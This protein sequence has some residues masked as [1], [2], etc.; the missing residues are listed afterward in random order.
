MALSPITVFLTIAFFVLAFGLSA[1]GQFYL[2]A[3]FMIVAVLIAS[4][5]KVGEAATVPQKAN[6]SMPLNKTA[7]M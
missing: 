7:I 6:G 1:I 3:G 2:S 4:A 5:L